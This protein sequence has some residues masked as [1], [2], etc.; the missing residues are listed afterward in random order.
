MAMRRAVR[1]VTGLA[2]AG[3]F[4]VL[5]MGAAVTS[6]GSGEGCGRSWPLC[7]GRFIPEFAVATA[8]EFSHRAVTGAESLL[9]LAASAG[10]LWGW[11]RRIEARLL[12]P[13]M[14]FFLLLQAGLGAWA[15]LYPQSAAVLA[16]HFG[17]SLMAFASVLL[18]FVFAVEAGGAT[19]A[20]RD[21][22]V[23]RALRWGVWGLTAYIYLV[24]YLGAYVRHTDATLACRDWPLCNGSLFPGFAGPVGVVFSHRLG[25]AVGVAAV[26]GLLAWT[27]R[28]GDRPD[29]QR[30]GL[31]ALVLIVLQAA[32]GAAVV[33]TRVNLFSALAH[34]GLMALLFGSLAYLCLHALPRPAPVRQPAAQPYAAPPGERAAASPSGGAS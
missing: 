31:V 9:I 8:I 32:S 20:L 1:W 17:I 24:V 30:A 22:P 10:V 33:W 11:G 21:R 26:A 6:T 3:M 7:N 5:V 25:A 13:M 23:P 18:A 4:L 14:L 2:T 12:A 29:L 15:V 28:A 16:A 19:D 34:S 27:R